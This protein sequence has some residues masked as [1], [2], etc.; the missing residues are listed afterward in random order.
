MLEIIKATEADHAAAWQIFHSVVKEGDTY[1]Y[2]PDTSRGAIEEL[3]FTQPLGSYD[4]KLNGEVVG[5]YVLR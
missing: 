5:T 1:V 3:R 4:A 2:D